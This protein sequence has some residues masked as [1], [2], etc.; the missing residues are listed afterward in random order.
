MQDMDKGSSF[1]GNICRTWTKEAMRRMLLSVFNGE[2][3]YL[4][5]IGLQR[6]LLRIPLLTR[7]EIM[8]QVRTIFIDCLP[9]SWDEDHVRQLL[10]KYGEIEKVELA[11]N[12]P[13]AGRK[14]YGFVTFDTHDAAVTCAKSINNTELGEGDIK[15]DVMSFLL[16]GAEVLQIMILGLSLIDVPRTENNILLATLVSSIFLEAHIVLQQEDPMQM[17]HMIKGLKDLVTV[18]GVAVVMTLCLLQKDHMLLWDCLDYVLPRGAP[19]Y[20]D[21]YGD[22]LGRSNLGYGGSRSSMSGQDSHGL[23]GS[24]QGMGYGGGFF[25][26]SDIGGMYSSTGYGGDYM[27]RESDVDG[28]SYSS[29]YPS[30]GMGGSSYMGGRGGSVSYY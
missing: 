22:R 5:L 11:R 27:S 15:V 19:P 8:A 25:R 21:A 12:M 23:Y 14:D 17:K 29:M 10:K 6:F 9:P 20:A 13:S 16:Q 24:R 3:F 28:S 30:H 4:G 26:S 7:D 1:L 2:K 18:R